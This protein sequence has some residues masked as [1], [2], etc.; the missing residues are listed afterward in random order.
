MYRSIGDPRRPFPQD[1]EMRAGILGRLSS[2]GKLTTVESEAAGATEGSNA[3]VKEGSLGGFVGKCVCM[4]VST[5]GQKCV[6]CGLLFLV[7]IAVDTWAS[8]H[9]CIK[10]EKLSRLSQLFTKL[11]FEIVKS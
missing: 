8:A 3:A 11:L 5:I 4:C 6:V 2:T 7:T 10:E 9:F 1:V